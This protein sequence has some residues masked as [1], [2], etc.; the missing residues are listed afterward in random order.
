MD[1]GRGINWYGWY[2]LFEEITYE[3][4]ERNKSMIVMFR[5]QLIM[6][7]KCSLCQWGKVI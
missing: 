6:C 4:G 1:N 5:R 2:V 7:M 3:V